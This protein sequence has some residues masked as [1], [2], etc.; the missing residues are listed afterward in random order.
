MI[1]VYLWCDSEFILTPLTWL[2]GVKQKDLVE[3]QQV[4]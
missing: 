4:L 3:N 2:A 1:V